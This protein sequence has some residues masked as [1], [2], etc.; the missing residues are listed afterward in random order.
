L[1]TYETE[2]LSVPPRTSHLAI[3]LCTMNI[4]GLYP[5]ELMRRRNPEN[6]VLGWLKYQLPAQ[7]TITTESL[8]IREAESLLLLADFTRPSI[9]S[10]HLVQENIVRIDHKDGK[11]TV[12]IK[13]N[14]RQLKELVKEL[15][16]KEYPRIINQVVKAAECSS[17]SLGKRRLGQPMRLPDLNDRLVQENVLSLLFDPHFVEFVEGLQAMINGFKGIL[18][19]YEPKAEAQTEAEK[20]KIESVLVP[21]PVPVSESMPSSVVSVESTKDRFPAVTKISCLFSIDKGQEGEPEHEHDSHEHEN[22]RR[23]IEQCECVK[24]LGP[25]AEEENSNDDEEDDLYFDPSADGI[26]RSS[27]S[28]NG[29]IFSDSG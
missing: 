2:D 9:D 8:T 7:L 11:L 5:C 1:L 19:P 26:L 13:I 21:V 4:G 6:G 29:S 20:H 14:S 16:R 24:D 10:F 15:H 12:A 25:K 22:K 18:D 27:T 23:Y 3:L 28:G 17:S